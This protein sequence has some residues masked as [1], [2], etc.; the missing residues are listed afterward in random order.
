MGQQLEEEFLTLCS[1][2]WTGLIKLPP[3]DKKT[4]FKL[5]FMFP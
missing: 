4:D 2:E 5:Y 3:N 1:E